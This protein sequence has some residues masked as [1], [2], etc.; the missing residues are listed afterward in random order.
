MRG[1]P[2]RDRV[3]ARAIDP[4]VGRRLWEASVTETGVAYEALAAGGT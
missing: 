4:T 1:Y 2:K 3:E